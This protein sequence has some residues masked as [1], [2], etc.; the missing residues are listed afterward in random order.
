VSAYAIAPAGSALRQC[1]ILADVTEVR[2]ATDSLNRGSDVEIEERVHPLAI[3]VTQ[4]CDLLWDYKARTIAN[5]QEASR[6][7]NKI[8]PNVLMC[9]LWLADQLRGTQLI[10]SDLW[11]RIRSNMDERYHYLQGCNANYDAAGEGLPDL[12]ID[13][14][15]VLTIP[16]EELYLRIA[17]GAIRR[18]AY[19]AGPY[20]QDLS[21]RFGYYHLRVRFRIL[22][23]RRF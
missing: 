2:I 22:R 14:K 20:M 11:R 8:L 18:R 19:L 16:P 6:H 5:V 17:N 7:A 12:A 21:N 9:E 1:E 4:D 13:F 15:R 3:V 23:P 10:A